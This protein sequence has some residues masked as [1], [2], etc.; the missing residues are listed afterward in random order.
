MKV[1]HILFPIDFTG[2]SESLNCEVEWLAERFRSKVT[3][4]HAYEIPANWYSEKEAALLSGLDIPAFREDEKRRL[5]DY[6]IQIPESQLERVWLEGDAAPQILEW[7]K[8]SPTDVLVMG[9]RGVDPLCGMLLGSVAMKVL[10]EAQCPIWMHGPD[11]HEVGQFTGVARILCPIEL[12]EETIPLLR[13]AKD[14]GT[15]LNADVHLLHSIPEQELRGGHRFADSKL[16][17]I[18]RD[19]AAHELA[20]KQRMAGTDFE[21]T[22]TPGY[23]AQDAAEMAR[24]INADLV[25]IGRGHVQRAFGILR[26]HALDIISSARCPV[27]SYS[28]DWTAADLTGNSGSAARTAAAHG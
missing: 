1:D 10:H 6:S 27:L 25:I 7:C 20:S 28:A 2:I 15:T 17:E 26:T 9:T 19:M 22:I 11:E 5:R 21:L 23:V 12:T 18:F 4:L 24:E 3:L 14:V 16:F 8:N 13:F